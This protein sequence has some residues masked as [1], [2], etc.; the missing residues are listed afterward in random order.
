MGNGDMG[1]GLRPSIQEEENIKQRKRNK[2][3]KLN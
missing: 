2:I 3:I 1:N